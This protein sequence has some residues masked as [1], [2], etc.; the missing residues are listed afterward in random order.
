[1]I[2][3]AAGSGAVILGVLE[4]FEGRFEASAHA[5]GRRA[6][7]LMCE[8]QSHA[9]LRY[10]DAPGGVPEKLGSVGW[11]IPG[12][13]SDRTSHL[14]PVVVGQGLNRRKLRFRG[15]MHSVCE[16]IMVRVGPPGRSCSKYWRSRD[17]RP[18]APTH[19]AKSK[20]FDMPGWSEECSGVPGEGTRRF[21]RN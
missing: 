12:C 14:A 16:I 21:G 10:A 17:S 19:G 11:G 6:V 13:W 20:N 8:E 7:I 1:M 3:A 18:L 2:L 15:V 9:E 4:A 5:S